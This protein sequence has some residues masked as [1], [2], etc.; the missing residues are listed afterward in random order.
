[1][2]RLSCQFFSGRKAV[3]LVRPRRRLLTPVVVQAIRLSDV[4]LV[5][6]SWMLN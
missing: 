3:L 2:S 4:A 1:M 5:L 6:A